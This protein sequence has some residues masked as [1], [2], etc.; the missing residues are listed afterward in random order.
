MVKVPSAADIERAY[1]ESIG[2]VASRYKAG[3]QSTTNW[4]E[5][6]ASDDAEQLWKQK[7]DEAAAARRRHRAVQGVSNQEWQARAAEL[8][9]QRIAPGMQ[10]NSAK[11]TKAFEP[12]RQALAGLNLPARSS[13]PMQNVTQRVGGVVMTMVDTKKGVKG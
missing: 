6:A 7:L 10:A 3:V 12:Y 13:D 4:Q 8:G 5:R 2:R 11:R 9:S 1:Q